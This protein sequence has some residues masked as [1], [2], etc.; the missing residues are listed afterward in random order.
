MQGLI[1]DAP[2]ERDIY[3]EL[4]RRFPLKKIKSEEELDD[5]CRMIDEILDADV[6]AEEAQEYLEVLEE[7]VKEYEK[8]H[9]Q[10]PPVPD[11]YL[12]AHLI[13]AKD[14]TQADVARATGI[15]GSTI[16]DI[17]AGRR[18]LTREQIGKLCRYFSI[19]PD[20]FWFG[21]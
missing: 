18:H 1:C 9:H 4:I 13:E 10:I 17:V 12:L 6:V 2:F 5:A 15:A 19:S 21:P 11:S 3:L 14:V 20:T 8:E 7:L 16:S